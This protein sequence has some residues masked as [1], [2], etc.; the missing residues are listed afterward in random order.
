MRYWIIFFFSLFTYKIQ[1]QTCNAAGQKPATA[2]PVCG[3]SV[4]TQTTVPLCAGRRLPS[5]SCKN[6]PIE[7]VNP[8]W[9]KFTCWEA[10]TLG[11]TITPKDLSDDY[12]W[13]VYDVTNRDPNDLYT[14]G[15]MVVASNWSGEGGVTGAGPSGRSLFVCAGPGKAL[16]SSMPQLKKGHD[17][18]LLVSHFTQS[19]SGYALKFG[20][21]TAVI[22]DSIIP[23]LKRAEAACSGDIVRVSL[24][25]KIKCNSLSAD[26][27]E[28]FVTP[29]GTTI[30]NAVGVDCSIKF[31]TD[32]IILKLNQELAPG[33]YKLNIKKG[34]DGNTMLDYCD[35]AIPEGD[36]VSFTIL[37]KAPT[38]MD[39]LAPLKCSPS[40]IR[41]LF[42]KPMLCSSIAANGSDFRI[43]GTYPVSITGAAGTCDAVL[44]REVIIT[45]SRPL[46]NAGNF[47]IVLQRGGDGNTLLN[48]CA[49]ETPVGSLLPFSI[50]DT[51]NADF[52]YSIQY[53]CAVDV[54][55]YSHPTANGVNSWRWNLDDNIS[56]GVQ[57]PQAKYSVF[58]EK[59]VQL[60]AS[61]GFC[62]DTTVQTVQLE[63]AL[64]ADFE[65]ATDNCPLE[66]V[67]FTGKA[68]GQIVDH[69]WTFGDGGS[70]AEESPD[71]VFP[72]PPK[73]KSFSVQYTVT[74][75]W[76]CKKTATKPILIY[77]SC[78][79][80]V[81][82]AFTPDGDGRND[83]FK[84]LN[85][86]KAEKF[87]LRIFN[88]W[89]QLVFTSNNWKQGWD[90]RINGALQGTGTYVW[91]VSYIDT[92]T[93]KKVDQK[94]SF[95]LIR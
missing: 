9:Y 49:D 53:G 28:F 72:Q 43:S 78:T 3:T 30:A 45:L 7:D 62:S 90:G 37:P 34:S 93:N 68:T 84:I 14:D 1:A 36:M 26:G 4:F 27:S 73:E 76:G 11:F 39:S 67:P 50:K 17:Y 42:R 33:S 66:P 24:N 35:N 21:G 40:Q 74:D 75:K 19:Q 31:D 77:T 65:V 95:V 16:Y 6:D 15:S 10:G 44:T 83:Y 61:N 82:N 89:G 56:S 47:S 91:M 41:L 5:P 55:D 22:T 88:R 69:W 12:D 20:G 81:P 25:E 70:S 80:Y 48:E 52:S 64:E 79:V 71:H 54:V 51:V 23:R 60:I 92:R 2:F 94:G 57:N 18:L 38:P 63:N 86:V 29:A 8:F 13:E 58:D 85:A 59:K 32:S 87:E 46:Q